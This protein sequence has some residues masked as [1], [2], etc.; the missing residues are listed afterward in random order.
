M[1]RRTERG[2]SFH[3]AGLS[4]SVPA[5]RD[6]EATSFT[7]GA[8]DEFRQDSK[9]NYAT[10]FAIQRSGCWIRLVAK[11][12]EFRRRAGRQVSPDI[13]SLRARYQRDGR[14]CSRTS[15]GGIF[16][17][18]CPGGCRMSWGKS[19]GCRDLFSELLPNVLCSPVALALWAY[20]CG[21]PR[22]NPRRPLPDKPRA[23]DIHWILASS[24]A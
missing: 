18:L 23:L 13:T 22:A 6:P 1:D 20:S 16:S 4:S 24:L 7:G 14:G 10:N 15:V 9:R 3:P 2:R 5:C 21:F 19:G 12:V 8:R 17:Q 11:S